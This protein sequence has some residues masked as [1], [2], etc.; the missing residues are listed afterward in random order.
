MSR[1]SNAIGALKLRQVY[2][3]EGKPYFAVTVPRAVM[4]L[5]GWQ[6]GEMLTFWPASDGTLRY[7]KLGTVMTDVN[8]RAHAY[9]SFKGAREGSIE[10]RR[11]EV[12]DTLEKL[13]DARTREKTELGSRSRVKP[14]PKPARRR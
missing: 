9:E 8:E 11:A 5:L 14:Q 13:I 2:S 3:R 1:A 6:P 7:G 4:E 12:E 10:A